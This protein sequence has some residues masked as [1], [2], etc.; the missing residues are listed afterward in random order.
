M[1]NYSFTLRDQYKP[2]TEEILKEIKKIT[3]P[4]TKIKK[5]E[6]ILSLEQVPIRLTIGFDRDHRFHCKTDMKV[7]PK[8]WDFEKQCMK[9]QGAGSMD[10]NDKLNKLKKDVDDYYNELMKQEQKPTFEQVRDLIQEYITTK[11]K[12][13]FTEN[14]KTFYQVYDEYIE[15]KKNELHS[16]TIQKFNTTKKLLETFT[17]KY[18]KSFTFESIDVNFID[19]FK[20]YLQYEA[21]NQKVKDEDKKNRKGFRDDT[22]AK[23]I[24]NLKNFLKWSYERGFNKNTIFQH[25][26]FRA[27]RDKN[28]DITT[29][30][31][32]EL[33]RFY[34]L[35]LSKKL[36]LERVRDMFCFGAFTGQRWSDVTAFRKEDLH[37]DTWI[38]EAYKTKKTTIIPLVGYAAPALN[39]L[40][41]YNYHLPSISNQKFNDFLKLAA[42]EEKAEL[43][44]LVEINRFQGNKKQTFVKPLHEVISSHMARRT[45]VSILLNIYRVPVPQVMEITGHSDFKTLKRYINKDREA[46]R[47]N[48]EQT[49]SVTEIMSIV[50]SA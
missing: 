14:E 33:K 49:R 23:Y 17:V 10:F 22:T 38:F 41:K 50:K 15:R 2:G 1:A 36:S 4:K 8:Q 13:R 43:T 16:R 39:I 26:Q 3:D 5:F 19:K 32:H 31:I 30:T 46:L 37:G 20:T 35:D 34:E 21:Y 40:K 47:T 44:R 12:P 48:L 42:K 24:E 25:S 29:M 27:K 18:Y 6:T 45:A 9:S 28:L 7:Y 11:V